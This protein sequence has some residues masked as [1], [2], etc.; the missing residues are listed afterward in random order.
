MVNIFSTFIVDIEREFRNHLPQKCI[1]ILATMAEQQI[2][3]ERALNDQMKIIENLKKLMILSAEADREMLSVV[4]K[5]HNDHD[6]DVGQVRNQ[7]FKD[8]G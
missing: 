2:Q 8:E 5:F 3:F 6:M 4:K 1:N 7:E